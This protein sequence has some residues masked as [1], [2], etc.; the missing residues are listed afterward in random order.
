MPGNR[1]IC[2][3]LHS[4]NYGDPLGHITIQE[5]HTYHTRLHTSLISALIINFHLRHFLVSIKSKLAAL[6]LN[7]LIWNYLEIFKLF[8][9]YPQNTSWM[10]PTSVVVGVRKP[11]QSWPIW[12]LSIRQEKENWLL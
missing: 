2:F 6:G 9:D 7:I 10:S 11:V 3:A 5:E 4:M 8:D 12:H 1:R